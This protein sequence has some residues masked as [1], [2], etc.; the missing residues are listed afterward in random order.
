MNEFAVILFQSIGYNALIVCL[1]SAILGAVAGTV[2]VFVYLRNRALISDAV[3]H[4]TLPGVVLGYLVGIWLFND[5]RSLTLLLF[6]AAITASI[7]VY[8]VNWIKTN[9][10]LT[11]DT[12]I[13]TVLSTFFAFG[14]VLLTIVQ[15]MNTVGQA[16]LEGF[17]L[18]SAAGMLFSEAILIVLV[19]LLV[20]GA[21]LIYQK[22]FT[23]L[24]FDA[25]FAKSQGYNARLL[26]LVLLTLLLVVI[27]I[28]LK[29]VGLV[30]IIALTI[31]PPVAAKFWTERV[32]NMTIISA[33]IGAC[34]CFVGALLSAS[35]PDLPTGGLIVI[36]LF[37]IFLF[38]MIFSPLRGLLATYIRHRRFQHLVHFR[39][40]LL[41]VA[42]NEPIFDPL[43]LK[44]LKKEKYLHGDGMPTSTGIAMAQKM[45]LDQVLWNRF[46]DDYP[47]EAFMLS[48]WSIKP[49]ENVLSPD[50]ITDLRQKV[51]AARSE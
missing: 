40:G 33:L 22:E 5:G 48:D 12:A 35:A 3:S 26:D 16:G 41:A 19:A 38:S 50:M 7:G 4:A 37:V 27:V 31:I 49:I 47:D 46:R 6:G 17:L 45:E 14:M 39:Q 23:L 32:A 43:T 20:G 8:T 13:G 9:T 30:L 18:G 11:E 2:G 21:V 10:R 1:G 51:S 24:C 28:G 36:T 25:H 29:I 15:S 42:R 34:G 44:I